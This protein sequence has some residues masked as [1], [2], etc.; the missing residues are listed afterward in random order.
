MVE[1]PAS[2]P[3]PVIIIVFVDVRGRESLGTMGAAEATTSTTQRAVVSR[4]RAPG[5]T[6]Q[7]P[8]DCMTFDPSD[9]GDPRANAHRG[10]RRGEVECGI[11]SSWVAIGFTTR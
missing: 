11:H 8:A 2:Q 7:P 1:P 6:G 10:L 4:L 9:I 5:R 3:G